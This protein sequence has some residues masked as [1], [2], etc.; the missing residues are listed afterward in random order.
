MS[1]SRLE[2]CAGPERFSES[3]LWQLQQDYFVQKGIDAWRL[4]EVP[5]YIVSNPVFAGRY[6]EMVWAFLEDRIRLEGKLPAP[7]TIC[8]LGAGSGEFAFHFIRQLIQLC[9]NAQQDIP[10]TF[11]Y[12]LT[13]FADST[14]SFLKSHPRFRSWIGKGIMDV[15]RFDVLKDTQMTLQVSG[16]TIAPGCLKSPL[17]VIANYL[18]DSIPQDLVRLKNN[19]AEMGFVSVSFSQDSDAAARLKNCDISYSYHSVIEPVYSDPLS[20]GLFLEYKTVLKD[21]YLLF[22]EKGWQVIQKLEK[23]SVK[24]LLLLSADKGITRMDQLE[25]HPLPEIQS[26]GSISMPVNIHALTRFA[27]ITGGISRLPEKENLDFNVFALV[28]GDQANKHASFE[29]AY[30]FC[31]GLKD[32][33]DYYLN[34]KHL[35]LTANGLSLQEMVFAVIQSEYDANLFVYFLPN[36]L[37][38]S[39][40]YSDEEKKN[41]AQLIDKVWDAY[42]PLGEKLDLGY[43]LGCLLYS[44]LEY[45]AALRYFHYSVSIYGAFTGIYYN[46]A[47]CHELLGQKKQAIELLQKVL[48]SDPSNKTALEKLSQFGTAK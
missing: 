6:A 32:P 1:D 24:G 22:P 38:N 21:S 19:K 13:D 16:E 15:A 8:E 10:A 39:G 27:E 33:Y 26:H 35:R 44:I 30:K 11:R 29:K 37:S 17:V 3:V 12:V 25:G 28:L 42:Y 23:L 20:G 7:V 14:L 9:E 2:H 43:Q 34:S 48:L 36:L 41:L 5:N 47:L 46:M 40:E 45:Q 31:T 4:H 18:F